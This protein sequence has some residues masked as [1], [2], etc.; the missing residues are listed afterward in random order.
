MGLVELDFEL[1]GLYLGLDFGPNGVDSRQIG[2]N[3]GFAVP[4]LGFVGLD[5]RLSQDVQ[6]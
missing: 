5:L 4:D 6:Y 1:V 3:S 2:L